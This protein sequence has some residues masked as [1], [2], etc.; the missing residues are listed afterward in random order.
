MKARCPPFRNYCHC[1][2]TA[3]PAKSVF[4]FVLQIAFTLWRVCT[5]ISRKNCFPVIVA[6]TALS[7]FELTQIE[8]EGG[9]KI[10]LLLL[11]ASVSTFICPC[12]SLQSP[13]MRWWWGWKRDV[14][15]DESS[16]GKERSPDIILSPSG[17]NQL[18][19]MTP[20]RWMAVKKSV[21]CCVCVLGACNQTALKLALH[22]Y[23]LS[24][25]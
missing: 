5:F 20:D 14:E 17:S 16:G 2:T 12:V 21:C 11:Q 10:R 4:R 6:L 8:T 3:H 9:K 15:M 19:L 23:I 18:I 22:N 1:W 13:W 25:A 24:A 7:V